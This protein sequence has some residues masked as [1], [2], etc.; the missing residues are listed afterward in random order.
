MV[1][2]LAGIYQAI[3]G[4]YELVTGKKDGRQ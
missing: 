2:S 3:T 4:Q 1:S